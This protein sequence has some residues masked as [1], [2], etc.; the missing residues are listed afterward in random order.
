M[1]FYFYSYEG[2]GL[3]LR[4]EPTDPALELEIWRP[5]IAKILP[6]GVSDRSYA[7]WWLF[8]HLRVFRGREYSV[9]LARVG[10]ALVHRTGLFPPYFRFPFMAREDLQIG[11]VWTAP[12]F[13]RRGIASAALR[14][15]LVT[16]ARPGRRIWYIVAEDNTASI[17]TAEKI[18]MQRVGVG[19]R[20]RRLGVG[21]LGAYRI[22]SPT[23]PSAGSPRE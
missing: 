5:G 7:V 23:S 11:D 17:R 19:E 22:T 10:G 9:V 14:H 20:T 8:H 16:C 13:R 1:I 3:E 21:L 2:N 12:E 4:G 15:A 6:P 18:G